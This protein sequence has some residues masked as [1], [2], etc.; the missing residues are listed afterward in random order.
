MTKLKFLPC[1]FFILSNWALAD[2]YRHPSPYDD[3]EIEDSL[4]SLL[5]YLL[6][7]LIEESI[8]IFLN[9]EERRG[10][11]FLSQET[12]GSETDR[13]CSKRHIKGAIYL[14]DALTAAIT[15]EFMKAFEEGKLSVAEGEK[16]FKEIVN[17]IK[18]D[19]ERSESMKIPPCLE[20]RVEIRGELVLFKKVNGEYPVFEKKPRASFRGPLRVNGDELIEEICTWY[21]E[22]GKYIPRIPY[23]GKKSKWT[24]SGF[25]SKYGLSKEFARRVLRNY[26]E[27]LKEFEKENALGDALVFSDVGEFT[28]TNKGIQF[29]S[30]ENRHRPRNM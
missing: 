8:K 24:I 23:C 1:L 6:E 20:G 13:Y 2:D 16:L 18:K 27:T 5:E 9:P 4:F 11:V 21:K 19:Y 10:N 26:K 25:A 7:D 30:Y 29:I 15:D 22:K 14:V 17:K 3:E 28:M 12:S